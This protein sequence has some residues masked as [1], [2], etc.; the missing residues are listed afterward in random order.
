MLEQVNAEAY[1]KL[2][3]RLKEALIGES[4]DIDVIRAILQNTVSFFSGVAGDAEIVAAMNSGLFVIDPFEE[5]LLGSS[6]YDVR[7]GGNFWVAEQVGHRVDFSPY[8]EEEVRSYYSG[9]YK[10]VTHAQWCEDHQRHPFSGIS[11]DELIIV[12][13]P[14][15]CILAHTVEYIGAAYGATTMMKARSSLGRINISACDDAGWG[16][17]GYVNRWTM[18]VRNKNQE[19]WVPLVVGMP[20]AQMVF[21]WV[22][23]STINYGD[24]GHYQ[25]GINIERIKADWNADSML[26]RFFSSKNERIRKLLKNTPD[27]AF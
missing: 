22:A 5:A 24:T 26:P 18:E 2:S 25:S 21:L 23:G 6:S 4:D 15:E 17:V 16:D 8:D 11:E 1:S 3:E 20:I 19:V 27:L 10:A 7:L 9:P 12:L 13:K 14:G